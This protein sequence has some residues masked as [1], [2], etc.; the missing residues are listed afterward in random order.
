MSEPVDP[1]HSPE[2]TADADPPDE[3]PGTS[4]LLT[5]EPSGVLTFPKK[6]VVFEDH[7]ANSSML[8]FPNIIAPEF[9]RLLETVDS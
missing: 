7:I 6:L 2:E 8:V 3:P 4:S 9:Q 1:R 5:F